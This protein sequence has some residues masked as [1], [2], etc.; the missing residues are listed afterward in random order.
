M[1]SFDILFAGHLHGFGGAEKSMIKVANA[2]SE[3]GFKVAI[4]TF[5]VNNQKFEINRNVRLYFI[6]TFAA[7]GLI[8]VFERY[9]K[10]ALL[11]SQINVKLVISFWFQLSIIF[12]FLSFCF[13][14]KVYYS[15]RGDPT[16]KEYSGLNGFIRT[17][18]F[19]FMNGFI[20]Q[21]KGAQLCFSKRIQLKSIVIPN[22]VYIGYDDYSLPEERKDVIVSVGRLHEQKNFQL[23]I[24][25]F[26]KIATRYHSYML[27][28]YGEGPLKDSLIQLVN[29]LDLQDRVV[30]K[31]SVSNIYECIVDD[32][33]FVLP[34]LF[35]GMPNALMEA[36]A[37][38]IPSIS[39]DCPPG[40]PAELI[41]NGVNGFLIE[42]NNQEE[43]IQV[44]SYVIQ[45]KDKADIVGRNAK[46]I[47]Y[48]H[49]IDSIMKQWELFIV[50]E[51][52]A[53]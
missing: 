52:S 7:H 41:K 35:E 45:H 38:G 25:A 16:D 10:A 26:S 27:H 6:E 13:R 44:L 4:V 47:C 12:F 9:R 18:C 28:I 21:T 24:N 1:E 11:L 20:F 22:P 30:F 48:T 31:G 8:R 3:K 15:E 43:L 36:M 29:S 37:L 32:S 14:Y 53:Y 51:L 33:I 39:V 40:G 34:S 2:L 19:P 50:N 49:S 17:V 23:L 5:D 42:N 46:Q